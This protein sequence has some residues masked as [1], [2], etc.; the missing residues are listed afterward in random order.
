MLLQERIPVPEDTHVRKLVLTESYLIAAT[1]PGWI[2][3]LDLRATPRELESRG[4]KYAILNAEKLWDIDCHD[5]LI[6]TAHDN[7]TVQLWSAAGR[8]RKAVLQYHTSRSRMVLVPTSSKV[9]SGSRDGTIIVWDAESHQVS[10]VLTGHGDSIACLQTYDELLVSASSDGVVKLWDLSS[11][12]CIRTLEGHDK[13]VETVALHSSRTLLATAAS[14]GDTRIWDLQDGSCVARCQGHTRVV[15]QFLNVGEDALVTVGADGSIKLWDWK[16]GA[17]IRTLEAHTPN[18]IRGLS[19]RDHHMVSAGMDGTV[20]VWNRETWDYRF[21]L[22]KK[23]RCVFHAVSLRDQLALAIR[24]EDGSRAVEL[25]DISEL[26]AAA[27]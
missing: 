1:V 2:A 23:V 25:W 4:D 21:E 13:Y 8:S 20:K 7:A 14:K 10:S 15:A 12:T 19:Y 3:I 16:S 17:C 18:A 5:D 22:R 6:A 27:E 9:V 24:L 26:T 11:A